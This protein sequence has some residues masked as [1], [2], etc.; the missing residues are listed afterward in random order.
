[1]VDV[2]HGGSWGLRFFRHLNV[3]ELEETNVFFGR[4]H[5][6]SI[7]LG[8]DDSMVWF[9]TKNDY[10]SVK[11]FYSSTSRRAK[12]FPYGVVWNSWAPTRASFFAWKA[13]WAKFLTQDRLKKRGWRMP[14]RC[15][16]SKAKEEMGDLILLHCLK[17]CMLWQL[18]FALF[19][20]QWIM[21]SSVRRTLL[22]W[23]GS[24]VGKKRK[25]TWK[26][27][28]LCLF[29]FIWRERN[30]GAFENCDWVILYVRDGLMSSLNFVDWLGTP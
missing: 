8:N 19:D 27:A 4:L 1:M 17:A 23:G 13:S 24:F 10:F 16:L 2:W 5:D 18:I 9:E 3:W 28:L 25:K 29:W 7:S 22:S 14:N 6:Y 12:P 20:I 21:H 30:M 26:A 15:C 11:S